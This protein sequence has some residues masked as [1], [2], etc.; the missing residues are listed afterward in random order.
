MRV[1]KASVARLVVARWSEPYGPSVARFGRMRSLEN[2]SR[3]GT[4]SFERDVRLM[5]VA[6]AAGLLLTSA[7]TVVIARELGPSGRGQIAVAL[8]LTLVLVQVGNLGLVSANPFF[9]ARDLHVV[10]R[11]V[12][13][14]L[15]L[16]AALGFALAG[17]G[18]LARLA[19]PQLVRG[20]TG[21]QFEIALSIVPCMLLSVF[22]QSILLGVGKTFVYNVGDFLLSLG[23]FI[24][25]VVGLLWLH[26]GVAGVLVLSGMRFSGAAALYLF[27]LVRRSGFAARWPERALAA[28]MLKYGGRVYGASLLSFLV[29]RADVLLVNA[30]LGV[31]QA[32]LYTAAVAVADA[33]YVVPTAFAL[34]LFPRVARGQDPE[35]SASVFRSVAVIYGTVC[36][37]SVPVASIAVE[38]IYGPKFHETVSLYYWL[39]PG[40]FSLGLLSVLANHFAGRG[41][42]I[43]LVYIW[44]VGL[45]VNVLINMIFLPIAGTYIA[46]LSSSVAYVLLFFL[47]ARLFVRD[48]GSRYMTLVPGIRDIGASVRMV[49]R[50]LLPARDLS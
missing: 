43:Q 2:S 42:P 46:S 28:E 14:S 9:A 44:A 47:H 38:T 8:S 16:S 35:V 19:L 45:I 20:V 6:R 33:L 26:V 17:V 31:A 18:V 22:L 50:M 48:A 37:I 1:A 7:Q 25:I 10:P 27:V 15:W 41:F 11:L 34:N 29:I 39:A 5:L 32:G 49:R 24:G 40:V 21:G 36:L 12:T 4:R 13:V 3:G 23:L 30:Y